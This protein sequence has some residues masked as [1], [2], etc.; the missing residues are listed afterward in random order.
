MADIIRIV[1]SKLVFLALVL[2]QKR[3]AEEHGPKE[4]ASVISIQ[5]I[6]RGTRI[7]ID[8]KYKR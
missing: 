3:Q 6:F 8:V 4:N 1:K 5:R 2:E 7:R